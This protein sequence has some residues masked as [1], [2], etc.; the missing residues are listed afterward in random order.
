MSKDDHL[1]VLKRYS[2]ARIGLGRAG[3]GLPNRHILDFSLAYAKARD[4]IHGQVD[5]Q[6]L[7]D[8]L[9]PRRIIRVQSAAHDRAIYLRRPDLGRRLDRE[10]ASI[11]PSGPFD[12]VVVI[13]DGLS[14]S[15]VDHHAA[16]LVLSL[17][18]SLREL[19]M[20]PTIFAEQARV[21]VGDDIA[22]RMNSA[23]VV[24]LIGERPGLSSADSLSAYVTYGASSRSRDSERNCVSNIHS[25]G[26]SVVDASQKISWLVRE[27]MRL[28]LSGVRLKEA[29]PL[30]SNVLSSE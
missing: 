17:E 5:F 21:A 3:D 24:V 15:A 20:G 14:S 10:S 23:M 2:H 29:A 16:K 6:K 30:H 22:E 12:L 8:E 1:S 25:R 7:A 13:A 9:S 26:L 18:A 28:K 27:S 4:A 19:T 11:L